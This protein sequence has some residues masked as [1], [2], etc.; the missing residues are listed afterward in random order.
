MW[1]KNTVYRC[2]LKDIATKGTIRL[3]TA[4]NSLVREI[5][6]VF[7]VELVRQPVRRTKPEFFGPEKN[8]TTKRIKTGGK[9][10]GLIFP[11]RG[12]KKDREKPGRAGK[13]RSVKWKRFETGDSGKT[14]TPLSKKGGGK[15]PSE[16][17]YLGG[18]RLE[19]RGGQRNVSS[20]KVA[21]IK[22]K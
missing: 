3:I 10:T 11:S 17:T 4:F 21:V 9:V 8:S 7:S 2:H 6:S 20:T 14:R 12:R 1:S 5:K 13:R 22:R 18:V 15:V 16:S 19:G